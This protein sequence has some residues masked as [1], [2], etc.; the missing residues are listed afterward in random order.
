MSGDSLEARLAFIFPVRK[1]LVVRCL[2]ICYGGFFPFLRGLVPD[3][4]AVPY[5]VFDP[6]EGRGHLQQTV[7]FG[8]DLMGLN[9]RRK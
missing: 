2:E 8:D 6:G 5:R 4:N 3:P 1:E 7:V 9:S